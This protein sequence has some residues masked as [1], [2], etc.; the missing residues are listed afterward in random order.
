ML[1]VSIR[2]ELLR[3][4]LD[5]RQ[6]AR[7]DLPVHHPRPVA[8]LGARRPDRG[9]VP[10]A[11]SWRSGRRSRSSARRA[12]RTRRRSC[13]CRPSP[14]PPERGRARRSG[15]SSSARRPMPS[16]IP[17]GC[18][19]HPRCP[20]AFDRCRV[21]EPPLFE[22]GGGHQAACWL[23]EG[24]RSLPV[25]P[26]SPRCRRPPR[27][28]SRPSPRGPAPTPPRRRPRLPRRTL[29]HDRR[30]VEPGHRGAPA[31][32]HRRPARRE[33]RDRG[34]RADRARCRGRLAARARGVERERVRR[35]PDRGRAS[36]VRRPHPDDRRG[37]PGRERPGH[38]AR[39]RGLGSAGR[40]R[41]AARSP[42]RRRRARRASSRPCAP[43]AWRSSAASIRPTSRGRG[44]IPRSGSCAS[45]SCWASGSTTIGTTSARCSPSRRPA[46][47]VR[48]ATPGGS[49]SRTSSEGRARLAGHPSRICTFY[50]EGCAG[51]GDAHRMHHP[52]RSPRA[53]RCHSTRASS[54]EMPPGRHRGRPARCIRA[55]DTAA[56]LDAAEVHPRIG[57]TPGWKTCIA[58]LRR[59]WA[60]A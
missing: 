30:P 20:L 14:D 41:G 38:P 24:G 42:P 44:C 34:R 6:R 17:P 7:P 25:M 18:R 35:P 52:P 36:R 22:V 12:T 37:R 45:T 48:W 31:G 8:R 53:C 57:S 16:H 26:G 40:R 60:A 9:D 54:E 1:D 15:R 13:R 56:P 49:A 27:S 23:A 2:T 32:D 59:G 19:F 39:P 4:M 33:R 47:G 5:L 50:P 46:S 58:A 28:P 51:I 21:E 29:R 10:R 55:A 43:T 3:L 11:R